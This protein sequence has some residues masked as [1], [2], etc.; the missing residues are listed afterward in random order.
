FFNTLLGDYA[1]ASRSL[2]L[3]AGDNPL[4]LSLLPTGAIQLTPGY[5]AVLTVGS[6]RPAI[7]GFQASAAGRYTLVAEGTNLSA[8]AWDPNGS[9]LA[10]C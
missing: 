3:T 10:G 9:P 6:D 7:L 5:G 8:L 4:S 1:S 2:T